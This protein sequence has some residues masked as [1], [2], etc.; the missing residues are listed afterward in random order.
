MNTHAIRR[1]LALAATGLLLVACGNGAEISRISEEMQLSEAETSA[2]RICA[3][4]F[5]GKKKPVF[6]V[7]G[8]KMKM[9]PVPL[10]ICGCTSK[11]IA[12]V[13]N[14]DSVRHGFPKFVTFSAKKEKKRFPKVDETYM[15]KG[16]KREESVKLIW[17]GFQACTTQ[18]KSAYKN[19][20]KDL[21][22]PLKA[23]KKKDH[24]KDEAKQASTG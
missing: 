17:D 14:Q 18:Y 13:F 4:D 19:K 2:F 22:K 8:V 10:E 5:E 11:T 21:F 3:R 23:K 9:N 6:D 7:N 16:V 15:Q 20:A 12:R 1:N 24:G